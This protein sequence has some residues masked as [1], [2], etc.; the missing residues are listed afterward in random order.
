MIRIETE[1]AARPEALANAPLRRI[2]PG[3]LVE[4][5]F[6]D[7]LWRDPQRLTLLVFASRI[8]ADQKVRVRFIDQII[9][10]GK[11][12][13]EGVELRRP[14]GSR[15]LI[16]AD[17]R[18]EREGVRYLLRLSLTPREVPSE[19]ASPKETAKETSGESPQDT[20]QAEPEPL[21][22][23]RAQLQTTLFDRLAVPEVGRTADRLARFLDWVIPR[24]AP[25]LVVGEEGTGTETLIDVVHASR[26]V[27]G[28]VILMDGELDRPQAIA[29]VLAR[30]S[31]TDGPRDVGAIIVR[32]LDVA[33]LD[34]QHKAVSVAGALVRS[35]PAGPR[36]YFTA[37]AGAPI[38]RRLAEDAEV[39]VFTIPPLRDRTQDI[40][41]VL[42]RMLRRPRVGLRI[43]QLIHPETAQL[44]QAYDW[45]GNVD[46]LREVCEAARVISGGREL[47]PEDLPMAFLQRIEELRVF[48]PVTLRRRVP[49][50]M[51]G[52]RGRPQKKLSVE[53]IR[54]AL[55]AEGGSRAKAA[56]RLG[57]SRTTLWRKIAELGDR[58]TEGGGD[59]TS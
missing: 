4:W 15:T 46:E 57:V 45:P 17:G 16:D 29:D 55:E 38:V 40:A 43:F 1:T 20:P 8:F 10:A 54:D 49:K 3:I 41:P 56:D 58:L 35:G 31:A 13:T 21:P 33:A 47:R 39:D 11:A 53:E 7:A 25:L 28:S 59:E 44:L 12:T 14:D 51:Q 6:D 27:P 37:N 34:A 18:V 26:E 24:R 22:A 19:A 30:H 23:N 52:K 36:F 5:G 9:A 32:R 50:S 42:S 48:A 2:D